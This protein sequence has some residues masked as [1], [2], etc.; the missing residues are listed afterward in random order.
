MTSGPHNILANSG[1]YLIFPSLQL[2]I[3]IELF[4]S[5]NQTQVEPRSHS[6]LTPSPTKCIVSGQATVPAAPQSPQTGLCRRG[7]ETALSVR[8]CTLVAVI[9][10]RRLRHPRFAGGSSP[11]A[12]PFMAFEALT[13]SAR[14]G[15]MGRRMRRPGAII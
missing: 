1:R 15:A 4:Y 13:S 11:T 14:G 8:C 5:C 2:N 9:R 10:R 6:I 3:E 7:G 12:A